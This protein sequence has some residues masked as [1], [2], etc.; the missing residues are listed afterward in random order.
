MAKKLFHLDRSPPRSDLGKRKLVNEVYIPQKLTDMGKKVRSGDGKLPRTERVRDAQNQKVGHPRS[1]ELIILA[2][3]RKAS[4]KR[5]E[6]R[7]ENG[8]GRTG[9][10]ALQG[11]K[12]R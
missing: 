11:K 3:E 7:E 5:R 12:F 8:D 1:I 6:S 10:S 9:L 4:T 2:R